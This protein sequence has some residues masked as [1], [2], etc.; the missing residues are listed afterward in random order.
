MAI[1]TESLRAAAW[2]ADRVK[3]QFRISV[4]QLRFACGR[5]GATMILHTILRCIDIAPA[6][7]A[8]DFSHGLLDFRIV[9]QPWA[10]STAFGLGTAGPA[11]PVLLSAPPILRQHLQSLTRSIE[12]GAPHDG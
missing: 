6:K 7:F 9:V 4:P 5:Q 11:G 10:R 1:S 2:N 12:Q 3:T 8:A